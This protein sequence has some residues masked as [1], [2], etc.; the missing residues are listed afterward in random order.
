MANLPVIH[1]VGCAAM[2]IAESGEFRT[3]A[4]LSL[5]ACTLNIL[6]IMCLKQR[7]QR[8][9]YDICF[10]LDR[11][12]SVPSGFLFVAESLNQVWVLDWGFDFAPALPSCFLL[13][14]SFCHPS[15]WGYFLDSA[16]HF[17]LA[18]SP[19]QF[20]WCVKHKWRLTW[21][22]HNFLPLHLG[23]LIW[24][25]LVPP[26]FLVSLRM[27]EALHCYLQILI[28]NEMCFIWWSS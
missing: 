21:F 25:P 28:W 11:K 24:L 14:T 27:N 19:T 16:L 8:A 1:S 17:V 22:L 10:R 6:T 3:R 18:F 12:L 26:I 9:S 15:R 13:Q 20:S 4:Y 5:R 7:K 23:F 2:L